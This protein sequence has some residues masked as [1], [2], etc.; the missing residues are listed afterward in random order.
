LIYY[1]V[2]TL[3]GKTSVMDPDDEAHNEEPMGKAKRTRA[4][5]FLVQTYL[6]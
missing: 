5:I 4:I 1:I 2:V 3:Q 6:E